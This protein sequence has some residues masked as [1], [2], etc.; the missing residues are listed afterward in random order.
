MTGSIPLSQFGNLAVVAKVMSGVRPDRPIN[1]EVLGLSDV[2]WQIVENCWSPQRDERPTA[3][4]VL[5]CL[6]KAT[7]YWVPP[8]NGPEPSF[9]FKESPDSSLTM[10]GKSY[11]SDQIIAHVPVFKDRFFISNQK[12]E[13]PLLM[14][15]VQFDNERPDMMAARSFSILPSASLE[16]DRTSLQNLDNSDIDMQTLLSQAGKVYLYFS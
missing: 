4:V 3:D 2:I 8:E 1:A 6:N 10:S 7:R 12:A 16:I 9:S 5:Q 11:P 13:S 14:S 15:E